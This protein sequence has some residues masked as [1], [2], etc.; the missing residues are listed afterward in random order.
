MLFPLAVP[1]QL[2]YSER[3]LASGGITS[4]SSLISSTD[5]CALNAGEPH[6]SINV[7]DTTNEN[8]RSRGH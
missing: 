2:S 8:R 1:P 6:P 7:T 4:E 3:V 5:L